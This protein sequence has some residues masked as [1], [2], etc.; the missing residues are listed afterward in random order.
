[1]QGTQPGRPLA[2][3]RFMVQ[4]LPPTSAAN[5]PESAQRQAPA[6]ATNTGKYEEFRHHLRKAAHPQTALAEA[7]SARPETTAMG[8]HFDREMSLEE[9]PKAPLAPEDQSGWARAS[10]DPAELLAGIT[11]A[12]GGDAAA[13]AGGAAAPPRQPELSELVEGWVRRVSLGG[14]PRRA[15]ARLDIGHGQYAGAELII[16]AESGQVSVELTLPEGA[17][18]DGLS[19]RLSARLQARGYAADVAVR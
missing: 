15:V 1:L 19:Q 11:S 13:Q 18:A 7:E 3:V 8:R 10:F 17:S 14:D 16:A 9:D 6:R 12:G 2:E 4:P 5:R